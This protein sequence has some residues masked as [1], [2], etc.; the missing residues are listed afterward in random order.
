[1]VELQAG[2]LLLEVVAVADDVHLVADLH[3]LAELDRGGLD[4]RIVMLHFPG[5][6]LGH[7][8]PIGVPR[9]YAFAGSDF[10]ERPSGR[11]VA[12]D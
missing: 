7:A 10:P 8:L 12:P 2:D 1:V 3:L 9:P 5:R 6:F 4:L 11:S